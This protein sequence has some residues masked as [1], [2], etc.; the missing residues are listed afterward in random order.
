MIAWL[1]KEENE[2][3]IILSDTSIE[4]YASIIEDNPDAI[5]FLSV[6]GKL[7]EVNQTV[8]KLYGYSKEE[9]QGSHYQDCIVPDYLELTNQHFTQVLQG[10]PC[11]YEQGFS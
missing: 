4:I 1:P 11:E 7:M 10:T 6:D 5:F 9:M 8:T 3:E 2:H